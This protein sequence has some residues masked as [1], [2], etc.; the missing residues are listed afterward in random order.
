MRVVCDKC[1]RE[2]E[3][4]EQEAR[5]LEGILVC[6]QCLG[7]VKV[8]VSRIP[9]RVPKLRTRQCPNCGEQLPPGV[10]YCNRCGE[11]ITAAA[12]AASVPNPAPPKLTSAPPPYRPQPQP[13]PH[14]QPRATTAPKPTISSTNNKPT[15]KKMSNNRNNNRKTNAANNKPSWWLSPLGCLTATVIFVLLFFLIYFLLGSNVI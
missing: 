13:Q 7:T 4:T 9:P 12:K 14:P 8:D 15:T 5:H 11:A 10:N 1:G 2:I 3:V 6:P